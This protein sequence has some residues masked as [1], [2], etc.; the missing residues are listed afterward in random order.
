MALLGSPYKT[1]ATLANDSQ[2][3]QII[4]VIAKRTYDLPSKG[5]LVPSDEQL[6]LVTKED[7]ETKD[8]HPGSVPLA[9][10]DIMP[11]KPASDVVVI[12]KAW[13]PDGRKVKELRAAV[14]VGN[15]GRVIQ[16]YGDR[17]IEFSS[18]GRS[19]H[20]TEP[21]PFESIDITYWNAYGGV[22]PTVLRP[23]PKTTLEIIQALTFEEHLGAYP[24]N[25]VGKGY[26]VNEEKKLLDGCPLPNLEDPKDLLTPNRVLV[27]KPELW[28]RQPLPHG[29]G[30]FNPNWYPRSTFAGVL[31]P[32]PPPDHLD[33]FPEVKLGLVPKG[34]CERLKKAPI[35]EWVDFRLQNG[36]SP[37]LVMPYLNGDE[38]IS[39]VGMDVRGDRHF[40]LPG[41]QPQILIRFEKEMLKVETRLQ[42][43]CIL[44]E[45]DK[46]FQ[47]WRGSARTPRVL[48]DRSPTPDD[49]MF[50]LL[51]GFDIAVDGV[52]YPHERQPFTQGK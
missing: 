30:W 35:E 17:K 45:Q 37:G 2:G 1:F 44:K 16:I 29:F 3:N 5:P 52:V 43:V 39:L 38:K 18:T 13:A 27:R 47:V 12:G 11:Y 10:L 8:T 26:V 49:P 23:E 42:T 14:I 9:E 34:Q 40:A 36:A 15:T 4:S 19:F 6:D 46:L 31:P 7:Y 50:D 33:E 21:E 41:E 32:F 28:W 24:R 25:S 20:F 51:E 22:D 48:P